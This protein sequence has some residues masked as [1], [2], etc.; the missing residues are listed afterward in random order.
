LRDRLLVGQVGRM[1]VLREFRSSRE[2][3]A[4]RLRV[5]GLMREFAWDRIYWSPTA[6]FGRLVGR[7][8][9]EIWRLPR[10]IRQFIARVETLERRAAGAGHAIKAIHSNRAADRQM[11]SAHISQVQRE[12]EQL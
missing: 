9:A 7:V 6:K 4:R 1:R 10:N 3:R 2:G 11:A 5:E 12:L 8:A